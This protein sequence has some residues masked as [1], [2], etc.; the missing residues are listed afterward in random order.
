MWL[1]YHLRKCPCPKREHSELM[2]DF[3]CTHP[4]AV[5]QS[6]WA[7]SVFSPLWFAEDGCD[8]IAQQ[9]RMLPVNESRINTSLSSTK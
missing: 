2:S 8:V 9:T 1:K 5:R 4:G 6:Y 7:E 3:L